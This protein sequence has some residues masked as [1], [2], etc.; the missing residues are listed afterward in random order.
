LKVLIIA[1]VWPEPSSS[2]A[3]RRMMDLI[4]LFKQQQWEVTFAC[5]AV[6]SEYCFPLHT[7]SVT[8]VR[9]V[10][11]DSTFDTFIETLSPDIV[12]YD[13]FMLEEQ[14]S[15]RVEKFCPDAISIL[16]TSDLHCLRQ[17]R[18]AA[19][20][21][22]RCFV[23]SDLFNEVAYREIASIQRCDLTLIISS[24]EIKLL[25]GIFRVDESLIHYFPFLVRPQEISENK[26]LWP[27][28]ENRT[29]F[30][31]IGNFKH[32]PNWD[33]VQYLK[34]TIWPLIKKRMPG[35]SLSIYGAYPQ[36][37]AFQLNNEAQKFYIKGR[38]DSAQEVMLQARVCLSPLRFGAGLK[39]KL[40]EAMENGTPSITTKLGAEAMHG[41]LPWGG[42]ISD[43]PEE[44]A[45]LAVD[46]YSNKQQ[47]Q[48]SQQ[49]GLDILHQCYNPDEHEAELIKR[50]EQIQNN[51]GEHRRRNFQGG[52]L[53][54]HLLKSTKYMSLWIEEKNKKNG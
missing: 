32:E 22:K 29:G 21:D 53:R 46:L 49:K 14:F 44:I 11:N 18:Q 36:A 1:S 50:I 41:S 24:Y 16:E 4:N 39:G 38:A 13:R 3:G 19:L 40:L 47:W 17:A 2:A 48:E 20:K 31:S 51:L 9:V 35:A 42:F 10:V 45:A 12:L 8:K 5:T 7:Q 37:K 23:E 30:V 25:E 33:S 43:K 26:K 27:R 54:H 28:Y 52:M 34:Q 6:D 15:W